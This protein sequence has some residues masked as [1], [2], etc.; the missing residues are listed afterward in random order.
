[1][2]VDNRLEHLNV[3]GNIQHGTLVYEQSLPNLKYLLDIILPFPHICVYIFEAWH[4]LTAYFTWFIVRMKMSTFRNS[5]D[6]DHNFLGKHQKRHSIF[7]YLCCYSLK[8]V[9][10]WLHSFSLS[11]LTRQ[12]LLFHSIHTFLKTSPQKMKCSVFLVA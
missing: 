2:K 11:G 12:I 1:M 4:P 8:R 9:F 10:I 7:L 3:R 6:L 5:V